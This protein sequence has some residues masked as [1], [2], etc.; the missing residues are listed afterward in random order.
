MA[1]GF[2]GLGA[3]GEG[4]AGGWALAGR[5]G[6]FAG[7]LVA[8]CGVVLIAVGC[9]EEVLAGAVAVG[10]GEVLAGDACEGVVWGLGV[11]V[12]VESSSSESGFGCKIDRC[13]PRDEVGLVAF[14]PHNRPRSLN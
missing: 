7:G 9:G 4:V 5:L 2:G 8:G 6:E 14:L 1:S 13:T 10:C 12:A 11:A 3:L